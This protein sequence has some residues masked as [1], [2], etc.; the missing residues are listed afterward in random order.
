MSI[1]KSVDP[2]EG[3]LEQKVTVTDK[4]A[5]WL[6]TYHLPPGSIGGSTEVWVNKESMKV[7]FSAAGQ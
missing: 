5:E 3:E 2:R 6:V 4:G 1:L 7:T